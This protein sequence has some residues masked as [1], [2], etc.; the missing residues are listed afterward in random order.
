M[1]C[2]QEGQAP[3][4]RNA[5]PFALELTP[6]LVLRAYA[7]GIFPMAE[8]AR[9]KD[10]FWVDPDRRGVIPLDGLH[11]SR[12]LRK[13]LKSTAW[14]VNIDTDFARVIRACASKGTGRKETWINAGIVAAYSELFRLGH[15]H[16]VEVRDG[17]ALVGGLYGLVLGGA[18]FGESMFHTQTGASKVALVHLVERLK[19]GGFT[20]LDTQFMTDHL[21]SLGGIEISRAAYRQKL[22]AALKL[23][24]DFFAIDTPTFPAAP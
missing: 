3:V 21:R 14:T 18:F 10:L 15:C 9:S 11:I 2:P 13:A 6:E 20:L 22:K 1:L 17:G 5:D 7:H 8:G 12:S 23:K 4:T 24:A 16:T 19:A